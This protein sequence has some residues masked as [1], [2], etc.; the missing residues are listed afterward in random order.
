MALRHIKLPLMMLLALAPWCATPAQRQQGKSVQ[1]DIPSV[2]GGKHE[3]QLDLYTPS[4]ADFPTI[5]FVHEGGLTSGDR[6]DE[7]YAKMCATF[8]VIGIGCAATNYRLAP[9]HKWPAEPNDVAAAFAWLKHSIG[10]RP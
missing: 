10:A 7:P 2:A 6:K 5:L 1:L 9:E 3:Q 4:N 8:Q